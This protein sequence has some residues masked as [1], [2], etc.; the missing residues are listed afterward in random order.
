MSSKASTR[1]NKHIID[2]ISTNSTIT[3][4][5]AHYHISI[6]GTSK[7]ITARF[8]VDSTQVDMAFIPHTFDCRVWLLLCSCWR[9]I[10]NLRKWEAQSTLDTQQRRTTL[11]CLKWHL[12]LRL[13][14]EDSSVKPGGNSTYFLAWLS[15][16]HEFIRQEIQFTT[17]TKKT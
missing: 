1:R 4:A 2:R 15:L 9:R 11:A 13:P 14:L 8:S 12:C 6:S 7:S 3:P 16:I 17:Y 5:I 10:F